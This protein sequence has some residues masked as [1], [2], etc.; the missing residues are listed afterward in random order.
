MGSKALEAQ[1]NRLYQQLAAL[2]LLFPLTCQADTGVT[3]TPIIDAEPG[4]VGLGFGLRYGDSPYVGVDSIS[5]VR[6]DLD[7]DLLPMYLYEGDYLWAHGTSWGVHAYRND[8]FEA[9][10]LVRARFNRLEPDASPALAGVTDRKQSLDGGIG[11][12]V[13]GVWGHL[14][15]EWVTDVLDVNNGEELELT[16]RHTWSNRRWSVSPFVSLVWQDEQLTDYYYGVSEAES[17]TGRP[18]YRGKDQTFYRVGLNTSYQLTSR[19]WLYG[20]LVREELG[21]NAANSPL[22]DRSHLVGAFL[23]SSYYFGNLK[24]ATID[25][26]DTSGSRLHEWSWKVYYGYTA[27]ETFHKVHRGYFQES[28]RVDTNLAGVTFGKLLLDGP[29][30]DYYGRFS[31]N[32]RLEHEYQDD[33]WEYNL[34]V[35]AMGKGYFPRNDRE[36]FRYG[37]GFGFSYAEEISAIERAK[38]SERGENTAR[39][40][41]YLEAQVDLP[42]RN[43]FEASTVR[44]CYA[45]ISIIHRS[46]IFATAD[47]LNNVSGG[48]DVLAAHLECM[49]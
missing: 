35:M 2:V 41:N 29:R 17:T 28:E 36:V 16:Y 30:V 5:S 34:Y 40:L 15:A 43:F 13:R 42:L 24:Q 37:F 27:D 32:R 8:W 20:N 38:Q 1:R 26:G 22:T 49:Q 10:A 48:S 14:R 21:D 46:G 3:R 19:W 33:F 11:I 7:F 23:G 12:G 4:T 25:S 47:I 6:N 9:D 39:F 31:L 44:D 18:V 45:G